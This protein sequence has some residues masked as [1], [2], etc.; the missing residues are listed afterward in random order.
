MA[1]DVGIRDEVVKM[2]VVGQTARGGGLRVVVDELPEKPECVSLGETCQT[3]VTDLDLE[4][5]R[6]VMQGV[7]GSIEFRLKHLNRAIG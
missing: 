5:V 1:L 4:R 6:L 7:D 2:R 3:D